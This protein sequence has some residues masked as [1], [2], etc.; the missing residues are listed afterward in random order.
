MKEKSILE[1]FKEQEQELNMITRAWGFIFDITINSKNTATLRL[2]KTKEKITNFEI[3]TI[4]VKSE[5]QLAIKKENTII[6]D[7]LYYKYFIVFVYNYLY[8]DTMK[9]LYQF[10]RWKI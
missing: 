1:K 6:T 10:C 4:S 8:Y 3:L 2:Y 5:L 7:T 9:F